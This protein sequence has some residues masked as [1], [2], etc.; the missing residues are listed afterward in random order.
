MK[1][2]LFLTIIAA[3]LAVVGCQKDDPVNGPPTSTNYND[4][5]V[6]T[7]T[8]MYP[9]A[10]NISWSINGSYYVA[11]FSCPITRA[12]G[13][14]DCTAWFDYSGKWYMTETDITF[15]DLPE[16][17]QAAF[18][19]SEYA[20]WTIDDVD[21][22]ERTGV[23]TI[24]VIEVEGIENGVKVEYDLYYT[25]DGTLV[26]AVADAEE[27]YDYSDY[28][29]ADN[30]T[31]SGIKSYIETNYPGARYLDIDYEDGMTEVEILYN[32]VCYE[33]LF[34]SNEAW[35]Y[36][37]TELKTVPEIVSTAIAASEYASYRIDDVDY[38]ETASNGNF[39]LVDLESANGDVEVMITLDGVLT[40]VTGNVTGGTGSTTGGTTGGTSNSSMLSET[41]TTFINTKYPGATIREFEYDDGYLEVEIYHD[42][43]EKNVYF[44]G[45][46]EWVRTE[47]DVRASEL[48][49]AVTTAI[50][51]SQYS[52]YQID[53][54]EYVETPTTEYYL[55]ELE[56]GN[57]EV[58]LRITPDGTIL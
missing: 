1:R 4:S 44:N 37:K 45:S 21:M 26:K 13:T 58:T 25:E 38:Y 35:V 30:T 55:I 29:P 11:D 33:L 8:A 17:V 47:W 10:T 49:T 2:T 51:N 28:I 57:S 31:V 14:T 40:V 52:T 54:I 19:A 5:A 16:A 12:G 7:L 22:L 27:D 48:P 9:D 42:S 18:L 6:K 50:Q 3:A 46:E 24:Y 32:G 41:V 53:D 39:Y 15:A 20:S 36:T 43:R 56:K 34:D 23:E